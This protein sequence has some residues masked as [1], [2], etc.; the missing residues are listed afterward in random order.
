MQ[1]QQKGLDEIFDLFA[2][3]VVLASE[4]KKG[5]EDC[6]RVYSILTDLYQPI[7]E[8]FRDLISVPK[9]NGYQ[10]LHTT[11]LGPDGRPVEIQIRTEEMH[12]VAEQGVAAHWKYKEGAPGG[13]GVAAKVRSDEAMEQIYT[14]VRD[15][16]ENPAP[17]R[18]S[19]FVKEFQ[20]SLYDEEIY[21][22]TPNGDLLTLPRGAT[23]V[24]F[25]FQVHSE[26]GFH[27]IGAKVNGRIVPLSYHLT[28]GDQVEILTSKK[29]T[30]NPDW[31]Q[32]VV[33]QK[34]RSRIPPLDQREAPQGRRARPRPA[35]EK[36]QARQARRGR[37]RPQ[38]S[39]VEPQVP[40]RAA[41][42]LRDRHRAVRPPPSSSAPSER[43]RARTPPTPRAT[44][45]RPRS[46]SR[47]RSLRRP[48]AKK[49][50]PRS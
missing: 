11:V 23:P 2:V 18:A 36:A 16:M 39:L 20:L 42:L 6:W 26:V 30:P 45:A 17:E 19:D 22:F 27:C 34:A 41:A 32:F 12:A 47:S 40:E 38:P 28:S 15:L 49:A 9:S 25:A 48:R 10:S 44:P 21:V 24:D 3:R 13:D 8:R 50:A 5:R 14:W 33:T 1:V 43:A 37:G 29:Q 35:R 7:P 31:V 4:G 46:G